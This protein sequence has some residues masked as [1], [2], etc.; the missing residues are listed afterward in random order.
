MAPHSLKKF[1]RARFM[2]WVEDNGGSLS[3]PTNPYEV[4]RY[5]MWCD[6]DTSRPS[7]HIV[8]KRKND[9]LTYGGASRSHYER[10][11]HP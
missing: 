10:M 11:L 7:T 3:E 5:R 8:Y 4:V 2:A 9:T 1:D 6:G